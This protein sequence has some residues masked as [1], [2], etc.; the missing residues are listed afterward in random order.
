MSINL[1]I[2]RVLMEMNNK[3][4]HKNLIEKLVDTH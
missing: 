4:L 3:I 2:G 1:Y